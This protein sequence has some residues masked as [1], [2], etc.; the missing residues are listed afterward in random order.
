[1][2]AMGCPSLRW[3]T[4]PIGDSPTVDDWASLVDADVSRAAEITCAAAMT[5]FVVARA[6]LRSVVLDLRPGLAVRDLAFAA[7]PTGRLEVVGHPELAVSSSHTTA[8]AAAAAADD[9]PVGIDAEPLDRTELPRPTA[10]LTREELEGIGHLDARASHEAEL[11]RL[12][13]LHLWVAKE[14]ALKAWPGPGRTGRRRIVISCTGGQA[15]T[16]EPGRMPVLGR[17][18]ATVGTTEPTQPPW[19]GDG[20]ALVCPLD[21]EVVDDPPG[22]GG[23]GS[24]GSRSAS[25]APTDHPLRIG[26]DWY[27]T[28]D[29]HL[30]AVAHRHLPAD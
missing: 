14:A 8:L 22:R 28:D 15:G 11:R 25:P 6:L 20:V 13:L 16:S 26:I 7:T 17:S 21:G 27:V 24:T 2:I 29:A 23:A 1:V 19:C 18:A 4:R 3:R 10:W 12:M 9:G 5:R 30:V